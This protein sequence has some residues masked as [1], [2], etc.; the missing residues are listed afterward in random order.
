VST[1]INASVMREQ[2]A[3]LVESNSFLDSGVNFFMPSTVSSIGVGSGVGRGR[4][5][6]TST[7][8]KHTKRWVLIR[9]FYHKLVTIT[10]SAYI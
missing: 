3:R 7:E 2:S 8:R 5:A 6:R 9:K 10:D 4:S 1:A